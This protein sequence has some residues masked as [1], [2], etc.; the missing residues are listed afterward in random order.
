MHRMRCFA[1]KVGLIAVCF[2]TLLN[3]R[4]PAELI[5]PESGRAYPDIA[6]D[7]NGAQSYTYDP[8]TP[9]GSF[10]V[11]N[12]PY[13]LAL[14]PSA[15]EE[16]SV[17]PN[18]DGVRRQVVRLTLDQDGRLVEDPSNSYAL[19]GT[20][21]VRGKTFGGLLLQGTPTTFG[22][23]DLGAVGVRSS[24]VFDLNMKITGGE[25]AQTFGPDA[26]MRITPELL[27]DFS[28]S[29]TRDFSGVK[30]GSNTR[31]Y[32]APDP[33][34]APEPTTLVVLLASCGAALLLRCRRR[35][36]TEELGAR[37]PGPRPR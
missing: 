20:V 1:A 32:H 34:L 12:T 16:Y 29:F 23:Q 31:G 24:D 2:V 21:V 4:A 11:T 33:L 5:L 27:S 10:R 35:I 22:A 37:G 25:L 26:Y 3:A 36:G 14:G 13:L 28:G 15:T 17:Q 30:A 18:S 7:I 19:Y 9:T 6:A 8:T